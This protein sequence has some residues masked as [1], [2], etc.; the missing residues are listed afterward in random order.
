LRLAPTLLAVALLLPPPLASARPGPEPEADHTLSPYF[1][2]PGG[3]GEELPLEETRAEVAVAG[4]I[5]HVTVHQAFRNRGARP[6]EAVY[7]FPA[8]TRAA[9]HALRMRI[10]ERTIEARIDRRARARAD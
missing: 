8:S 2:V 10:G 3:E 6:I 7:V 9:V 1:H 5:A 4:P